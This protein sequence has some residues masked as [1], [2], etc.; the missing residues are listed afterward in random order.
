VALELGLAIRLRTRVDRS[1]EKKTYGMAS[2]LLYA[3]AKDAK[4][5]TLT[6]VVV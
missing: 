2:N 3:L 5:I 4:P 6:K 1:H